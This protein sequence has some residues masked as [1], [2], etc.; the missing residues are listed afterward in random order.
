MK[1]HRLLKLNNNRGFTLLEVLIAAIITGII[2]AATF[3]FYVRMH[4]ES[5]AQFD[6][7]E[8]QQLARS[9]MTDIKK[10]LRMAGYKIPDT[11]AP[12][13]INGDTLTIYMQGTLPVD[14]IVYYLQEFTDAEYL[15]TPRLPTGVRLWKLMK[16]VNADPAQVYA[17]F[18]TGIRYAQL[19]PSSVAVSL[20]VQTAKE[21]LSR[22]NAHGGPELGDYHTVQLTERIKIRNIVS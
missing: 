10:N 3:Q 13:T 21:D 19:S 1:K 9:S 6:L 22:D 8:A 12:Y 11:L 4:S 15:R 17:D 14:T 16:K 20:Q 5:E 2:T 7:S 18:L